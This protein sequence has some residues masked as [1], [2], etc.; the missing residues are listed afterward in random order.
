MPSNLA[1][2]PANDFLFDRA[3]V[4]QF[5]EG[6]PEQKLV[7]SVDWTLGGFG[8]TFKATSY[9]SVLVANNNS[10]LDYETGNAVLLD[11]EGRYSLPFGVAAAVGV[12]NLT[13]EYPNATP[14]TIN[15]ATGSVGFPQYSP[16]GFNGRYYYARLS[17]SF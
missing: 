8:A 15:G 9:D 3:N 7:A 17:Y 1:I 13:D 12:N 11:L 6:T 2:A 10:T 16:Y 14:T 4:L 5:E